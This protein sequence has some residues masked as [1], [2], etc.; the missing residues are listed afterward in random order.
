MRIVPRTSLPGVTCDEPSS[1]SVLRASRKRGEDRTVS[2]RSNVRE[3]VDHCSEPPTGSGVPSTAGDTTY[4]SIA[5]STRRPASIRANTNEPGVSLS[6]TDRPSTARE[7]GRVAQAL[8]QRQPDARVFGG[9]GSVVLGDEADAHAPA[10]FDLARRVD[11][12]PRRF[13]VEAACAAHGELRARELELGRL[14]GRDRAAQHDARVV[15]ERRL[16]ARAVLDDE[17]RARGERRRRDG[18]VAEAER[19]AAALVD[20]DLA[21]VDARAAGDVRGAVGDRQHD[22]DVVRGRVAAVA[23][24]R[25][26]DDLLAGLRDAHG[27]ER[28]DGVGVL[29]LRRAARDQPHD[30]GADDVGLVA[31]E[32]RLQVER[33]AVLD[34]R[35]DDVRERDA[36]LDAGRDLADVGAVGAEQARL[37]AHVVERAVVD[38]RAAGHVAQAV[39]EVEAD[40]QPRGRSAAEVVERERGANRRSR[41]DRSVG[42]NDE[43]S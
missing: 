20:R 1:V 28:R 36:P 2:V 37:A 16:D 24:A 33:G 26:R 15:V 35:R 19:V 10:G 18:R 17:R 13:G 27:F 30:V 4:A 34:G 7:P 11:D 6:L 39:G 31:G 32:R 42:R 40:A 14:R 21:A 9:A 25:R 38:A 29:E 3:P 41:F 5:A 8:G 22:D 43:R 12:E 23:H